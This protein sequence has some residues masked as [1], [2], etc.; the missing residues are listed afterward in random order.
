MAGRVEAIRAAQEA[1]G[2]VVGGGVVSRLAA[3]RVQM[4]P[5]VL[6]LIE[7]S[8]SRAQA[9]DARGFGSPGPRTAY[10]ELADPPVQRRCRAALLLLAGA[11]VALRLWSSW[12]A[13]GLL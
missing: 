12:P 3:V 9:L 11:A 1:R 5:L 13:A 8:G 6:G 2:L 10:R 7:D 4:V